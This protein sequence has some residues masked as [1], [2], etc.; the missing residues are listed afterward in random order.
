[1]RRGWW[2]VLLN[3]LVNMDAVATAG[4]LLY[5]G[6]KTGKLITR[7]WRESGDRKD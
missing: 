7:E 1:M 4:S 3:W 6:T 5:C 2:N